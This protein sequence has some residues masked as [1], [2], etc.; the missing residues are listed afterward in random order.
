MK[1]KVLP[2]LAISAMLLLTNYSAA[3]ASPEG[4][5][6]FVDADCDG[7]LEPTLVKVD[8]N[9]EFNTSCPQANIISVDIGEDQGT[10]FI[11]Y[12]FPVGFNTADPLTII[13]DDIDWLD[14]NGN[15]IPG[16]IEDVDCVIPADVQ[17][18]NVDFSSDSVA[19]EFEATTPGAPTIVHCD[20]IISH[21]VAGELLPLDSTA[22]L[23]AGLT[24]M[25]V[26]TIP[27]IL[28]LAG[29]GVYLVK[30]RARD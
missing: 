8:W 9:V 1:A 23:L 6:V 16:F 3:Y 14:E 17:I 21:P 13:V 15:Q 29:A 12:D 26:W 28:G 24:S 11:W 22:L 30:Y 27:T 4:D 19:I 7:I 18:N 5:D 25:S 20:L 2:L 10:A